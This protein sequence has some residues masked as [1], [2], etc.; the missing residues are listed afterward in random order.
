MKKKKLTIAF[1]L[2]VFSLPLFAVFDGKNLSRTLHTLRYELRRDYNQISVSE[3]RMHEEYNLQHKRMVDII[4]Q[5]NELSLLLY[6]QKQEYTFDLSFALQKVTSQYDEFNKERTPYDRIAN[7]LTLEIDRYAR[8]LESLRR[9]PPEME[10]IESDEIPD[11]LLYRNDTLDMHLLLT[12]T[13]L[14][15]QEEVEKLSDDSLED[16]FVLDSLGEV[17][18]D[19]CIYYAS[20]LLKMYADSRAVVVADS[21]H[22]REAYL[23]LKESYDYALERYKILQKRVFVEGQV[24]WKQIMEDP[25]HFKRLVKDEL[26]DKYDLSGLR[27]RDGD[28]ESVSSKADNRSWGYFIQLMV[29]VIELICFLLLWGLS[30]LIVLLLRKINKSID[31]LLTKEQR[32][33]VTLLMAIFLF[34]L[35][36]GFSK[37]SGI[38][39]VAFQLTK[40]FLWLFAAIIA[41]LLVRLEPSK[42]KQGFAI[43]RPTV[44]LAFVVIALRIIFAPNSLMNLVFPPLLTIFFIWQLIDCIR[45]RGKISSNDRF[46]AWTSLVINGVAFG[47]AIAG[48]IF[49]SLLILVWWYFQLAAILTVNMLWFLLSKYRDKKMASRL[50][51]YRANLNFIADGPDKEALMFGGSWLYILVKD[52]VLPIMM[53]FSIPFCLKRALNVFDFNDLF[54]HLYNNPFI[55]LYNEDGMESFR[56]S[57]QGLVGVVC[58]FFIFRYLDILAHYLWKKGRFNNFMKKNGRTFIRPEELNLVLG[59]SL[60][61]VLVWLVYII[62]VVV[63]LRIPTGSLA[64]IAGGLSAGIGLALK[65]IL[66]NF[67]YGLQL[68]SGRLKVGDWIECDGVRGMVTSITYQST[69]VETE[70]GTSISFLNATLFGKSFTNLTRGDGYEFTKILVRVS[71]G[72]DIQK[73][74]EVLVPALQELRTKDAYERE[75]VDPKYGIYIRF[76]NFGDSSIEV[77]V[78]Q[79]VLVPERIAY[80]DRAK[81]LIYNTLNSNGFSIPFPQCDIHVIKDDND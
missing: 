33:C 67:I 38:F 61:S 22:Y 57:F 46:F 78:K 16:P 64:L 34:L 68:M 52:V 60:I 8:L 5:C 77:A 28:D 55:H 19:S 72:T 23:R 42:I 18:R 49:I 53:M 43:Y 25:G 14:D 51:T 15:L 70:T 30:H 50:E 45:L 47:F 63:E 32:N 58:L 76:G 54:L 73:L 17:D 27:K 69:Q 75:I 20:E 41:S 81:E 26:R 39:D 21:I 80:T 4:K 44:F 12:G 56:L 59:N 6:S 31:N 35:F 48:Y 29:V 66:N 2:L 36:F 65:D 13:A 40:T 71:Y 24:P 11:S 79:Y 74:R 9:L 10:T 1:A 7:N 37:E 3:E 62:I